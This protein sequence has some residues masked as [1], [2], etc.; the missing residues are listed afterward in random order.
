MVEAE[1]G[2]QAETAGGYA[3]EM[4]E[5]YQRRQ[6][7][8]VARHVSKQDIVITT[9]LIPGRPAPV[10]ISEQMVESMK[11]GS[12]IVDLAVE[13]G[14][15]CPLSRVGEIVDHQGVRIMGHANM[16]GR[17]PV[18]A[19]AMYARNLLNFVA[20]F[21]DSQTGALTINWDDGIDRRYGLDPRW[22]DH[23]SGVCPGRQR[24]SAMMQ[25][26]SHY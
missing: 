5:D 26:L 9:A 1:E 18:D 22:S 25:E 7:E 23:P 19:S 10:L 12:I 17:L 24:R 21:I 3:K 15:N 20:P 16:P 14:G 4:S 13:Q 6:A 2:E 11:P 8:L